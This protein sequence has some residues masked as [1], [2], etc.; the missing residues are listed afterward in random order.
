MSYSKACLIVR[1]RTVRLKMRELRYMF[2]HRSLQKKRTR[3][4]RERRMPQPKMLE[5][6]KMFGH[7]RLQTKHV[8]WAVSND[9][10]QKHIR[11]HDGLAEALLLLDVVPQLLGYLF[12]LVK[13][14][15]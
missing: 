12:T 5:L 6:R 9:A 11:C 4:N 2:G 15:L 13:F 3:R 14:F 10:A 1:N 8:N 7:R